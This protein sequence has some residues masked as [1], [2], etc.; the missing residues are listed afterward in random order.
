MS[1]KVNYIGMGEE[2]KEFNPFN[3]IDN[4]KHDSTPYSELRI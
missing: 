1:H 2:L 3:M 4:S